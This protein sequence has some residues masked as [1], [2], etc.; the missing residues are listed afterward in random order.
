MTLLRTAAAT[1]TALT[2]SVTIS[3]SVAWAVDIQKVTSKQGI[4]AL[5]VEDYTVPLVAMSFT[6]KGGA[7]QDAV[8]KEGTAELMATMLDEGAAD[9]TSQQLQEALDDA[10]LNYSFNAGT[11]TFSG[12][13]QTI[14]DDSAAGFDLLRKM[15]AEPRF[16][17]EPLERMKA[18]LSTSLRRQETE[19]NAI[20]GNAMRELVY[21]DHPY[22][23]PSSGTLET[24]AGLEQS[25]LKAYHERVF[26][27]DN[28]II[29]VVGAISP[30]QLIQTLD[31]VFGDLPEQA[32]LT[33][34][35]E[36]TV[37]TGEDRH[38][39]LDTP[40]TS[41]TFAL[42]GI[43]R[44]D[45]DFFA[46]YLMNYVLGG[47]SFSSRLYDEVREKRG[48]AYGV[49]TYLSLND[50]S[51]LLGGGSA[52][53]ADRAQQTVDI[54]LAEVKRMAEEGPTQEELDRAK[55]YIT[56]SYAIS[57]LDTSSKIASVLV[58]IQESDLGIDYMDRRAGYVAEVT[59]DDV[60]RMAKEMLSADPSVVTVGRP[61]E[62][63]AN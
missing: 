33:P 25:D 42:P 47:G 5:L 39:D 23:R 27:R 28:L 56:G 15:L 59:L 43:K 40:Q 17:A 6:F 45:E 62:A 12:S 7:A 46:A 11:D 36:L 50:H 44:D 14:V 49:G 31:T 54:I 24:V 61:L 48:L 57:N 29:G 34:V 2:L 52:T 22:G 51:G 30:E 63:A 32:Q 60:K 20:A 1:F 18:A 16:D 41:I 10:G 4:T 35:P 21:G 55:A 8:G 38:I 53:Q 3:T 19:P 26:A 13:A 37:E 9:L 58:A